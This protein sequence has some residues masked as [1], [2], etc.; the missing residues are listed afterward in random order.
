MLVDPDRLCIGIMSGC[1][2]GLVDSCAL[3]STH[4]VELCRRSVMSACATA[5]LITVFGHVLVMQYISTLQLLALALVIARLH[6]GRPVTHWG[7]AC[8]VECKI[9]IKYYDA[10]NARY[11]LASLSLF[12]HGCG[13]VV[14]KQERV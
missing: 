13:N 9:D 14:L 7:H 5:I 4:A 8:K 12:H 2:M 3:G 6:N 11:N 1:T 10:T